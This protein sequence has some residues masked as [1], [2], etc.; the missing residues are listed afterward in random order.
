MTTLEKASIENK[1]DAEATQGMQPTNATTGTIVSNVDQIIVQ[2]LPSFP[3][4]RLKERRTA[5]DKETGP[6]AVRVASAGKSGNRKTT[7][8]YSRSDPPRLRPRENMA[9][10]GFGKIL[11]LG[12]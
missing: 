3:Y 4:D 12:L 8:G 7:E 2:L 10:G 11:M 1:S 5:P 6:G 9:L